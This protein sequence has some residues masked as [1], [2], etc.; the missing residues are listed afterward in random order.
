MVRLD[1]DLDPETGQTAM[2]ALRSLV[3]VGSSGVLDEPR[4]RTGR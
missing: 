3:D 2:T 4:S 1:G